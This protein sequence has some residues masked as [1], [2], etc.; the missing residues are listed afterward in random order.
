MRGVMVGLLGR[1]MVVLRNSCFS[2]GKDEAE[3][4]RLASFVYMLLP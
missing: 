2:G 1:S 4:A 3:L